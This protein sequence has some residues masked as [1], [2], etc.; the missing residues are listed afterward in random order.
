MISTH[1]PLLLAKF[2]LSGIA[3]FILELGVSTL[4]SQGTDVQK[5][6]KRNREMRDGEV[7][8]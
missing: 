6:R 7:E 8:T 2:V 5:E 3:G 1:V 4:L